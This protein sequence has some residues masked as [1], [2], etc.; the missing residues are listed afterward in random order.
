MTATAGCADMNKQEIVSILKMHLKIGGHDAWEGPYYYVDGI[1]AAADALAQSVGVAQEPSEPDDQSLLNIADW[2]ER[3]G[4]GGSAKIVREA[5][6]ALRDIAYALPKPEVIDT[7][8]N[9]LI[10]VSPEQVSDWLIAIGDAAGYSDRSA[11]AVQ[12]KVKS[13]LDEEFIRLGVPQLV[14]MVS[15]VPNSRRTSE[16]PSTDREGK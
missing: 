1:E 8:R 11:T 12:I 6:A 7:G 13:I 10:V 3:K 16:L 14:L 5:A 4:V 9:P 2:L 15:N